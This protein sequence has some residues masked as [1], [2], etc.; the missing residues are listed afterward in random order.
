VLTLVG[1][2]S[3]PGGE[4][5]IAVAYAGMLAETGLTVE[6]DR[7]FAGSPS[8]IA[9]TAP[10]AGDAGP[11]L[12]L[13]GHL[14]TVPVAQDPPVFRDGLVVAR[15][16]CDMKGALA[17]F[18]EVAAAMAEAGGPRRGGLLV[19]AYGQHEGSPAGTLHGPLRDLLRRGIH[20]DIALIGDGPHRFLPIAGKGSL[21]FEIHLHRPG[22]PT[23]E[24]LAGAVTPNPVMAAHRFVE[25]LRERA[26]H[27]TLADPAVGGETF[28]IGALR[29]GD[30]YN[31]IPVAA[32]IDGTRR[33][34][35]PRTFE[36]AREELEAIAREVAAEQGLDVDVVAHRSGQPFR[37]DADD[38]FV[39]TF[40][41]EAAAVS[42]APLPLDGIDLAS[43][44][45]HVVEL[46][47]IPV[48]LHGVD[49]A[50][51]HATPEWVP[52]AALVRAARTYARV[53]GAMLDRDDKGVSSLRPG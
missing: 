42:G 6:L 36:A 45:N 9:R 19:T 30:L 20:G 31:R 22:E 10:S 46:T 12:Q 29:G 52:V 26:T 8:V 5:R 37:I 33:Y 28:F 24:L 49:G 11:L 44:I 18:A 2:E 27:W 16:A 51:A 34:P 14:D 39:A 40:R 38:P 21:I 50:R 23:H 7:T 53:V 15:G 25:L 43:D 35:A 3:F 13:A 48:V 17:A 4:D 41:R 32:R 1:I 47:G